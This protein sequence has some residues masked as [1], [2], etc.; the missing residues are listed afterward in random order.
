MDPS[1][2]KLK[3]LPV[4][5]VYDDS[6][7]LL[8]FC[9]P[10]ERQYIDVY[11]KYGCGKN[12]P[13]HI[14][15]KQGIEQPETYYFSFIGLSKYYLTAKFR[16]QGAAGYHSRY[17]IMRSGAY[18]KLPLLRKTQAQDFAAFDSP[19]IFYV[20]T[21]KEA[22]IS[23]RGFLRP[24][25]RYFKKRQLDD[26][27]TTDMLTEEIRFSDID[28]SAILRF[29]LEFTKRRFQVT[30]DHD[31]KSKQVFSVSNPLLD[32]EYSHRGIKSFGDYISYQVDSD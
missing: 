5:L 21:S 31:S 28:G 1:Y 24:Y 30:H 17:L 6:S 2:R 12:D 16:K 32:H 14:N 27:Q 11:E 25:L 3:D 9:E 18:G 20:D 19:E 8:K 15:L 29:K 26:S 4:L 7:R 13:I 23:K 22:I 10:E